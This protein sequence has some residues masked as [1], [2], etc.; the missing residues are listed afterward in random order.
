VVLIIETNL[1]SLYLVS[2][3]YILSI[4]VATITS[5]IKLPVLVIETISIKASASTDLGVYW[6]VKVSI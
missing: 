6:L 4:R 2:L 5:S 1:L 3:P